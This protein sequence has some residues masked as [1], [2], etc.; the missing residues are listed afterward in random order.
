M[1]VQHGING[2]INVAIG[3]APAELLYV[4]RSKLKFDVSINNE[5]EEQDT[6]EVRHYTCGGKCANK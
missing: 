3:Y 1:E 5:N 4:S 6:P 2:I